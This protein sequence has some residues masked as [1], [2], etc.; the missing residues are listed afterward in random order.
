MCCLFGFVDYGKNLSHRQ[1]NVLVH[2]LAKECEERG[3]HAT[4]VAYHSEGKL[5]IFK[6]A[7]AGRKLK[8]KIPADVHVVLGHTRFTTQGSE[9]LNYNNHPFMG[10]C[11]G[12]PFAFAHNGVLYND[13]QLHKSEALPDSHIETDSYVAVQ[14]LEK[15][16]AVNH[17]SLQSMASKVD[18]SF[19]FTVLDEENSIYFV[20]GENPLCIYHYK[21]L[22]LYVYTS[23]ETILRQALQQV[24]FVRGN[25]EKV[26]TE[27]GDILRITDGGNCDS[28]KFE[29]PFL[30]EEQYPSYLPYRWTTPYRGYGFRFVPMDKVEREEDEMEQEREYYQELRNFATLRGYHPEDVDLMIE[31]GYGLDEIEEFLY[32]GNYL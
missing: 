6:K 13:I 12:N 19:V 16:G 1:K 4:G 17:E 30:I 28:S 25:P 15:Q 27:S 7:V 10:K 22:G 3:T 2:T 31:E 21:K 23:T 11:E 29:N 32:C 20:R 18:G 14:L 24:K 9:K 5:N 8:A 26:E